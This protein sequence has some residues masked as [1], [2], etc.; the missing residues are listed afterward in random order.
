MELEAQED[1]FSSVLQPLRQYTLEHLSVESLALLRAA[2]ATAQLLVDQHTGSIWK[3]AASALLHT[4]CF[5][6][7]EHAH[8]VQS[9]LTDQAALLHN[10]R[11]GMWLEPSSTDLMH[12]HR[13]AACQ[14]QIFPLEQIFP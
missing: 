2:S 8:A 10:L 14:E 6:D 7:A 11:A 9:T 13:Q 5:P 3:A 1:F 12:G 4:N